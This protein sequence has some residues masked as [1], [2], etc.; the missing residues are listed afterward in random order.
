MLIYDG[1]FPRC[2]Q[3]S[4]LLSTNVA[5]TLLHN[6]LWFWGSRQLTQHAQETIFSCYQSLVAWGQKRKKKVSESTPPPCLQLKHFQRKRFAFWGSP[7]FFTIPFTTLRPPSSVTLCAAKISADS[8]QLSNTLACGGQTVNTWV[9]R[10][11]VRRAKISLAKD[12][13]CCCS[14]ELCKSPPY[15]KHYLILEWGKTL[16]SCQWAMVQ[17]NKQ[18]WFASEKPLLNYTVP[19]VGVGF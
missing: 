16:W 15:Y 4:I 1:C 10:R 12:L 5:S 7:G 8:C 11:P 2:I 9:L 18:H 14:K 3:I 17:W 6:F 19:E 13:K